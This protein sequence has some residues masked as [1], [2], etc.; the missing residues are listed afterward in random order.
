VGL[1]HEHL[2][3]DERPLVEIAAGSTRPRCCEGEVAIPFVYAYEAGEGVLGPSALALVQARLIVREDGHLPALLRGGLEQSR[4]ESTHLAV[5]KARRL[6]RK[7]GAGCPS[8]GR[9]G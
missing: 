3:L 4:R 7:F 5:W 8:V 6:A 9:G 2:D 1:E